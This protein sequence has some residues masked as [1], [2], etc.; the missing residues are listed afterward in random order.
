MAGGGQ[1][2]VR[3]PP[4]RTLPPRLHGVTGFRPNEFEAVVESRLQIRYGW[5]AV[6]ASATSL[7]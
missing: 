5:L 4:V 7:F 2:S 1:C 3:S 6:V